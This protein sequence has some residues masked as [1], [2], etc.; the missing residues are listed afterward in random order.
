MKDCADYVQKLIDE[1]NRRFADGKPHIT[2]FWDGY[3]RINDAGG[4][5]LD[6]VA[7]NG[8]TVSGDLFAD[9]AEPGT[10]HIRPDRA[11][12]SA[13]IGWAQHRYAYKALHETL[14]LGKRGW[15]FDRDLAR[16]AY[17]LAG[18][19]EPDFAEDD[20]LSWSGAFD[21]MLGQH[22]PNDITPKANP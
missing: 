2:S 16:A 6:D 21:G 8:A 13:E 18:K 19:T 22:C 9:G 15:Y 10:V 1:T 17:S 4:Y 12:G 7:S 3:S 14:H 11:A 5:Q 20:Y